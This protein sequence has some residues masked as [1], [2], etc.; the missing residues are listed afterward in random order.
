VR[1]GENLRFSHGGS[2]AGFKCSLIAWARSGDGVALMTNG[3]FGSPLMTEILNSLSRE[4]GW[5]AFTAAEKQV[6]SLPAERLAEYAGTYKLKPAGTLDIVV[7]D[8]RVFA[9]RLYVI[10][11][12]TRRVEIFPESE[13]RFFAVDTNATLTF[14]RNGAGDVSMVTLKQGNRTREGSRVKAPR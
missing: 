2:N 5:P 10:P 3:D 8:G 6:I 7:E 14:Q 1:E 13:T 4:Y 12:G 9:D 11:E